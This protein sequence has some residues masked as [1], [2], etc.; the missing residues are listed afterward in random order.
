MAL[1][2]PEGAEDIDCSAHTPAPTEA[3]TTTTNAV[4]AI[5]RP[6]LDPRRRGCC[7][8]RIAGLCGRGGAV[9]RAATGSSPVAE[10][11][12]M[13]GGGSLDERTEMWGA[14]TDVV[15]IA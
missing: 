4:T 12:A 15:G 11:A 2:D 5:N 7:G 13:A 8:G 6:R 14:S 3:V 1:S 9:G 10:G